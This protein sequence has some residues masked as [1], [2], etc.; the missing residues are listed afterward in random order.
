MIK[1]LLLSNMAGTITLGIMLHEDREETKILMLKLAASQSDDS[2]NN[3]IEILKRGNQQAFS[4][5]MDNQQFLNLALLK[6]HHFV[7]PHGDRFYKNCPDCLEEKGE[8]EGN[9]E[10]ITLATTKGD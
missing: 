7:E 10:S 1:L 4:M 5:L 8:I 3:N 6:I 2:L 9:R